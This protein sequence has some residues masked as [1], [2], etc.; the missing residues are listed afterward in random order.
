[1]A[2]GR[3]KVALA[4]QDAWVFNRM[5]HVYD[6]RPPYPAALIDALAALG[7]SALDLGAGIGH[8]ALP[9][10]ALGRQVTAVEPAREMLALLERRAEEQSLSVRAVH[11]QA[12]A[13]PFT[14]KFDLVIV[15]DALHFLDAERAGSEIARVRKGPLAIV[16]ARFADAPYMQALT[17]LME[18]SAPRRVRRTDGNL[19]QLTALAGVQRAHSET[20]LDHHPL[21]QSELARL[22]ATIS[23]IGPAM[24]AERTAI[25]QERV[26][27]LGPATFS[28][29]LTLTVYR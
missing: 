19:A 18:E 2:L 9:L 5:A 6:A 28:R 12:E 1:M 22:L 26:A 27:A 14:D 3:R 4:D 10:A 16:S 24:N 17:A 25:F 8:I 29:E 21:S 20:F 11:A 7:Q 23:F 15:A 13:L